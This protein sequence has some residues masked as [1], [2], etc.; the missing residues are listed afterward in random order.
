MAGLLDYRKISAGRWR[1]LALPDQWSGDLQ[2]QVL[3]LVRSSNRI[4]HPQT[5][6]ARL[7]VGGE[8]RILYL[9]IFHP[10]QGILALK[11]LLRHSK[12]FRFWRQGI[13]LGESGFNVPLTIA[14]GEQRRYYL[15][16]RGFVLT[17]RIDGRTLPDFLSRRAAC[18][19]DQKTLSQKWQGIRSLGNLVRRFHRSGFVHGDLV[20]SNILVSQAA[21]KDIEFYFMDND[22]TR[23]L[24]TWLPQALWKRNLVQLNRLPLPGISLQDRIRFLRAYLDTGK[25]SLADRKLAQWLEWKT[26]QRRKECD[27]VDPSGNFRKLMRWSPELTVTKVPQVKSN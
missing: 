23:R 10:A 5:V 17:E 25:F 3:E 27:G 26:R 1:L 13:A 15:V 14:V 19:A 9:K 4:R 12:A 18:C 7:P 16:Q 22:R 24:P 2:K 20:A 6:E 21:R 8:T 11:D